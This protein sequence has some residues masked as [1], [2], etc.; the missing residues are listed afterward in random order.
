MTQCFK[1]W[2]ALLMAGI[3]AFNTSAQLTGVVIDGETGDSIPLANITYLGTNTGVMSDL[4]GTFAIE[5]RGGMTLVVSCLGYKER[6]ITINSS[7]PRHIVVDLEPDSKMLSEIVVKPGK[8]K[9]SRKNNPAVELMKRVIA[10]KD[11]SHIKRH[12]YVQWNEYQKITLSLNGLTEKDFNSNT[13]KKY[14]FLM[15]QVEHS[16]YNDKNIL[17]LTVDETVIRHIYRKHPHSEKS[18]ITG[19]QSLGINQVFETGDIINVAIQDLF[20]DVDVYENNVRLL[21]YPF[22]SPLSPAAITFY[23]FYIADTVKIEADSCFHLK[24][25]PANQQD[26]G[27]SG[28]L[29]ILK[30]STL[31]L[32]RVSLSIPPKSDV[33]YVDKLR[34]EQEFTQLPS[35]DWVLSSDDMIIEMSLLKSFGH[36]LVVRNTRNTGYDLGALPDV[37]FKGKPDVSTEP[38]AHMRDEAFWDEYRTV[39]RSESEMT[40]S[41]FGKQLWNIKGMKFLMF[42]IKALVENFVETSNPSL[43]DLGPVNT[44]ITANSYDGLRTRL[45]AQTTAHLSKHWFATGY[46]SHG[47]RH[48][49]NYYKGE[50]IYSFNAKDYL[51]R[52]FPKRTLS[53]S[54][55]YD[56]AAP[57]DRFIPT[58]KDN[59][60]VALKWS[61]RERLMFMN[62]QELKFEWEA[63]SGYKVYAGFS[64]EKDDIMGDWAIEHMKMSSNLPLSFRNSEFLVGVRIAP[65]ETYIN[66]KQRR[67]TINLDASVFEV[68]HRFGVHNFLGSS[69]SHNYTEVSFYRRFWL[70]HNWGKIDCNIK[71]GVEWNHVPYYM[72][73]IPESN[74]S[75]I[76]ENST[77]N[78]I[79]NME[80]LND[81]FLSVMLQW[82]MNGKLLNRIPLIKRLKWREII[83][84]NCLWGGLAIDNQTEFPAGSYAMETSKPYFELRAGV[85]NIFKLLH[86]EYVR[87]LNYNNLPGVTKNSVRF[88]MRATF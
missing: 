45:S 59:V 78:L 21:Q 41:M 1:I 31:H 65:G 25:V 57:S 82:D 62:R 9:Y 20:T 69:F 75:Y 61:K 52:E 14:P 54:S 29:Y 84:V 67:R 71:A 17:P 16:P 36:F 53:L 22:T 44:L 60:L 37:A 64:T 13:F 81:R 10:A 74:M 83:G 7:I 24:F 4:D 70:T 11:S 39:Q 86:V 6:K 34:I 2:L 47:W 38:S 12:D 63:R 76:V 55:T 48:H 15:Q 68:S 5:R 18:I 40:I 42:G 80:F 87:R 32:R 26:F 23:H 51:P 88:V 33:N 43:V 79:N 28:D 19:R 50:L 3:A 85:H 8:I 72:L 27:F 56:I 77:F 73:I 35:G 46:Y 58:D 49:K 30:D 66:T